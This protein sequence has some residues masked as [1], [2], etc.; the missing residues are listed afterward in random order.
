MV[1][2]DKIETTPVHG[3]AIHIRLCCGTKR[4]VLGPAPVLHIC[5]TTTAI[6]VAMGD[7]YQLSMVAACS[8]ECDLEPIH[9][10]QPI[11]CGISV[12]LDGQT[13]MHLRCAVGI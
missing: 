11:L 12:E 9:E 2:K 3:G 6:H 8:V 5:C 4:A 7:A 13:D 1:R 10:L